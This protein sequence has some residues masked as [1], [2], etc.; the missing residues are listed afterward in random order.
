MKRLNIVLALV[1]RDNDY[2]REQ[3]AVGEAAAR[4]LGVDL[5]IVYAEGDAIAQTRQLL[6]LV[7]P[8]ATNRPD[9][10]IVEPIGTSMPQ[11]AKTTVAAGVGWVVLNREVTDL[12][13]LRKGA[14]VPIG[15]VDRD[16]VEVG[17]I[18]A[19]QMAA[20]LPSGGT[21][22]YIEGPVAEVARQRRAG[23]DEVKPA[24]IEVKTLRGRWTEES[25]FQLLTSRL[26]LQWSQAPDVQLIGSQN[27]AMAMGARRAIEG[28]TAAQQREQ[29][30]KVPFTGCDGVPS[31]GQAW[32][33]QGL[34]TATVITPVLAG[35]ALDLL[36]RAFNTSTQMPEVTITP[37]TAFPPPELLKPVTAAAR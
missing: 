34:L 12:G 16:N 4:R 10:I 21:V 37:P 13:A 31:S 36:V 18:Q 26:Q 6:A 27:D 9:A 11:V 15:C 25:G 17:R 14:S 19:R 1:T 32:V 35:V 20:L 33:R 2:Q 3:A 30:L 5:R 28:L 7:R 23:L 29:W 24:N 8:G 22:L